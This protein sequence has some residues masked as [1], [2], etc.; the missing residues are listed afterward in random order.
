MGS[1]PRRRRAMQHPCRIYRGIGLEYLQERKQARSDW[2][3]EGRL[4]HNRCEGWM[5]A[6]D[7]ISRNRGS[8]VI[9]SEPNTLRKF[10]GN[11][12]SWFPA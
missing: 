9:S 3:W 2:L 1:V 5:L 4:T 12:R 6:S 7:V 10:S 8:E 11:V